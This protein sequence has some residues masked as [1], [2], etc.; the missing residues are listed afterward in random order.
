M[1]DTNA[2]I[3]LFAAG[4]YTIL[5]AVPFTRRGQRKQQTRWLLAYLA[6]SIAWEFLVFLTPSIAPPSHI[7]LI[8][9]I[10]GTAAL[11]VLT[12][13][14]AGWAEHRRWLI[15][16]GLA[17]IVTLI[18]D[19][20]FPDQTFRFS[21]DGRIRVAYSGLT[22]FYAWGLLSA[23]L[24]VRTWRD[25]KGTRLPWHANRLLFWSIALLVVFIGEALF[26]AIST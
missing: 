3:P 22:A 26:F 9:L 6:I 5:L 2:I 21:N 12:A 19:I 14:H 8:A 15:L 18:I 4:F 13:V 10:S 16:S 25:Y 24:L 7:A 17:I 1:S 11:G 20:L 23:Y